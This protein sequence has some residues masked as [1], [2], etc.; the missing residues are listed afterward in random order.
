M[1]NG[2]SVL[3]RI[4]RSK[5]FYVLYILMFTL[6]S[7]EVL[8]RVKG[9]FA[10]WSEKTGHAYMSGYNWTKNSYLYTRA[11]SSIF[12]I[13]QGEYSYVYT[14]NRMGIRERESVFTDTSA[15]RIICIGDSY[16]EGL[17]APYDSSYPRILETLLQHQGIRADVYNAGV[18][19]SDPFFEFMLL[20][21]KLLSAKPQYV[22]I[23]FN[24]SDLTD[25]IFRGGM[26]RFHT[27]GT[28]HYNRGPAVE[29]YYKYSYVVRFFL[30]EIL[31][32]DHSLFIKK[33]DM[34]QKNSEAVK[35][36]ADLFEN[37]KRL[38]EEN[39][40]RLLVIIQPIAKEL[41]LNNQHGYETR[42]AFAE[43]ETAL[44]E[45]S[46]DYVNMWEGL[47]GKITTENQNQYAYPVDCHFNSK[48]YE[49]F[50]TRLFVAITAK[51]PGYFQ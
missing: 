30:N 29:R 11:L 21:Q 5:I 1:K 7:L 51:H 34:I 10:T 46:V 19:G 40:F 12:E 9:K 49:L 23:T 16:T 22:L 24:S 15:Q 13:N 45:R 17:G 28:T 35:A 25:Y 26:E 48:G 18:A 3:P 41:I 31:Q 14:T 47:K 4:V 8:F 38:S 37:M 50:A 39:H 44:H 27:D 32:Y 43:M 6:I 42:A 20:K 36:Y 33:K 2:N